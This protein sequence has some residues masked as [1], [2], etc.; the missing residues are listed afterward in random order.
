MPIDAE[1]LLGEARSFLG[2]GIL[3]DRPDDGDSVI[4]RRV[5]NSLG[6]DMAAVH[7]VLG[8]HQL[9]FGQRGMDAA[10]DADVL[11][12]SRCGDHMHDEVR[13][14]LVAGLGLM[15]PVSGPFDLAG[16]VAEPRL[17]VVR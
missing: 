10:N 3:T 5:V 9:L 15:V 8:R 2:V 16:F 17:G 12:R 14:L 7:K 6:C 1:V 11:L 4:G 13:S